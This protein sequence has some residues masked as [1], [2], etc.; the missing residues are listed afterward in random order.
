MIEHLPAPGAI[1]GLAVAPNGR[2]VVG[3]SQD[4]T[5]HG[6]KVPGGS[7]FRMS[8]FPT[9]VSRLA[10]E[11]GGRWMACDA[12]DTIAC[13]DLSGTGPTGREALLAEGHTAAVTALCWAPT[14]GASRA[15]L[16]T[17][18][19]RG[20]PEFGERERQEPGPPAGASVTGTSFAAASSRS[21]PSPRPNQPTNQPGRRNEQVRRVPSTASRE[22]R[23]TAE[24]PRPQ[25]RRE[26]QQGL[27]QRHHE[28]GQA[29]TGDGPAACDR[30]LAPISRS[31]AFPW[32]GLRS[33]MI[34]LHQALDDHF[35][36]SARCG[37]THVA[38]EA[39][40]IV[41]SQIVVS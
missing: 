36:V 11:P 41:S 19:R 14:D 15:L 26:P 17:D 5:L 3:G 28:V 8:G 2:W 35:D 7:D 4:A 39:P 24:R 12:G 37:A 10:F 9:T 38:V 21:R 18:R 30:S 27:P 22:G 34:D 23:A 40:S 29:D 16:T 33:H 13:W 1:A 32:P 25:V 20:R 6:W 31:S